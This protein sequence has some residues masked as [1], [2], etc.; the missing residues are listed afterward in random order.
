MQTNQK[1]TVEE[2]K[3]QLMLTE[4]GYEVFTPIGDGSKRDLI[5]VDKDG[6]C[7]KAQVKKA[8][9]TSTGFQIRLYSSLGAKRNQKYY[10]T[11]ND[12]DCFLVPFDNKLYRIPVDNLI[13]KTAL[14]LRTD[15][16]YQNQNVPLYAKD[17]ELS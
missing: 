7:H 5:F 15:T 16:K 13:Y 9:K 1:G 17:Y 6:I 10:Y 11:K 4:M 2:L 8:V 12:I 14:V 3:A